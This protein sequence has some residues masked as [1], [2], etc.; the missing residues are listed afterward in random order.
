MEIYM[1]ELTTESPYEIH[2]DLRFIKEIDH[3]AFGKVIHAQEVKKNIDLAVKVINKA[4]AGPQIINKMK[5]EI[6]ILKKLNHN[7]IVKF[8]GFSETNNQLLIKMEYIKYGTLSRWMKDHHKI[9]EL[10]AS[11]ILGK[12]LSA[13]EYLHRMH[14]CHRDLKPENIMIS[15]ENDL[16]SIKI[17]D[18][19]LSAQHFNYL[20][21]NDYCGTFLYMAPEQIE[22]KLYTYSVDI[23]S[24]GILM[25]MLLNND[26]HPFYHKDDKKAD[27]IKKIKSAKLNFLNKLSFM[28]K[29]LNYKLCEPN[30]SWRYSASLA[31]K[32]PWITRNPN[33]EIPLTFNEILNK[34]NSKKNANALI[35]ISIF[36]NYFKK[37]ENE[38][39]NKELLNNNSFN[40]DIFLK[41][42]KN[43]NKIFIINNDYINKC[44][45]ISKKEKEKYLKKKEK[46][47]EALSTDEEESFE[48]KEKDSI[49][50]SNLSLK[51][52]MK[53]SEKYVSPQ[54]KFYIE[55]SNYQYLKNNKIQK[56]LK[57]ANKR[58]LF[59]NNKEKE[60]IIKN[61]HRSS[62][63]EKMKIGNPYLASLPNN[64]EF[65][66]QK[67]DEIKS[68]IKLLNNNNIITNRN[69]INSNNSSNSMN[70]INSF[71]SINS[72]NKNSNGAKTK[73]KSISKFYLNKNSSKEDVPGYVK[74]FT[75]ENKNEFT[76]EKNKNYPHYNSNKTNR[77]SIKKSNLPYVP[78]SGVGVHNKN[79]NNTT[80][81]K[82]H[83]N[84]I[85]N[86]NIIPLVLPFIGDK[87]KEKKNI[88][89]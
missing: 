31:I 4:G 55:E 63:K 78:G 66:N 30:P 88:F 32:H 46:Y 57:K 3:G 73:S 9:T 89:I 61:Y 19:G 18:F 24:I 76:P 44:N 54:K 7:N 62:V 42:K 37:K 16:S 21:N 79:S 13:I 58:N 14:I 68:K 85:G 38:K 22:K 86:Y 56:N 60:S 49:N 75:F 11:L 23:W 72:I 69:P 70:S 84:Y 59:L 65:K 6:A 20:S 27:F 15:K 39:R 1:N 41:K 51:K 81:R 36:L 50:N 10:E 2:K 83:N 74:E 26:K 40:Y 17:I 77:F 53:S 71:N 45:L 25:Y 12:V 29:N 82:Y 35:M 48:K 52:I 33:D 34:N 64:N 67:S 87:Q 47:F 43:K 8:Y 80:S 28:A 5:E